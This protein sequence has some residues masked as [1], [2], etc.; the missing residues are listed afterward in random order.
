MLT[1]QS[2]LWL[3]GLDKG[4][5]RNICA[6]VNV[7]TTAVGSIHVKCSI[8]YLIACVS[9]SKLSDAIKESMWLQTLLYYLLVHFYHFKR[10]F[11]ILHPA[12]L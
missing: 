1:P 5:E 10:F 3:Q 7:S 9:D 2:S 11:C 12:A 4:L 8:S 6:P